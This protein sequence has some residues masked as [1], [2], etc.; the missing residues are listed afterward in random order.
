[1][2]DMHENFNSSFVDKWSL[3]F[4]INPD[5]HPHTRVPTG[6]PLTLHTRHI[7][8]MC[9]ASTVVL[10]LSTSQ[11]S[12][13]HKSAYPNLK[14][15]LTLITHLTYPNPASDSHPAWP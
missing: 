7:T 12:K 6:R 11:S 10:C 4:P 14:L 9:T 15:T 5:N 2:G 8:D 3:N 13:T 1:M